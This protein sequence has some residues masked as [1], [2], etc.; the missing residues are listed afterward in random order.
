MILFSTKNRE[1]NKPTPSLIEKANKKLSEMEIKKLKEIFLQESSNFL[2]NIISNSKIKSFKYFFNKNYKNSFLGPYFANNKIFFLID[3]A[4]LL[5]YD[6]KDKNT[7]QYNLNLPR[8][9]IS[10]GFNSDKN[11]LFITIGLYLIIIPFKDFGKEIF[12]HKHNTFFIS[13]PEI[14]DNNI[15]V[16]DNDS[17]NKIFF[18][19][20]NKKI[21]EKE[22]VLLSF[23]PLQN[24]KKEI[25]KIYN[26]KIIC[27]FD[28]AIYTFD[29]NNLQEKEKCLFS[30]SEK[31]SLNQ[32]FLFIKDILFI[33]KN[34]LYSFKDFKENIYFK[35]KLSNPLLMKNIILNRENYLLLSDFQEDKTLN[36]LLDMNGNTKFKFITKEKILSASTIENKETILIGEKSIFIVDFYKKTCTQ[37]KFENNPDLLNILNPIVIKEG[38]DL[39]VFSVDK[40]GHLVMINFTI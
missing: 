33:L 2:K 22:K 5:V 9:C 31:N 19:L 23:R 12:K 4:I 7:K 34:N 20:K 24:N 13:Q 26:K 25:F 37:Y 1:E 3:G 21:E 10:G 15:I 28:I 27:D 14:I 17:I 36:I 11:N 40:N 16:L 30:N 6:I 32:S 29:L 35:E 18:D 38:K 39:K 8:M